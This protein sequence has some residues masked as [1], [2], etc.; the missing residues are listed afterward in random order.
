DVGG[1]R[2]SAYSGGTGGGCDLPPGRVP[3]RSR[4]RPGDARADHGHGSE[5]RRRDR[6]P[7]PGRRRHRGPGGRHHTRA[8]VRSVAAHPE[9]R[10]HAGARRPVPIRLARGA[11]TQP[12]RDRRARS[13]DGDLRGSRA[14]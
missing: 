3:G 13:G 12:V 14:L 5:L 4:G 8:T 1:K 2:H 6:A 7:V 9:Q 11:G 10:D